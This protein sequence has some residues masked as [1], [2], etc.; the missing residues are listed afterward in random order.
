[1]AVNGV[2]LVLLKLS[3]LLGGLLLDM[4]LLNLHTHGRVRELV[5]EL[6]TL[7]RWRVDL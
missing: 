2:L 3:Y 5:W 4:G 1:V 7:M 6:P